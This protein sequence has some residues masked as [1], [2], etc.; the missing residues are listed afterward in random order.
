MNCVRTS[1]YLNHSR[2]IGTALGCLLA[3]TVVLQCS[4]RQYSLQRSCGLGEMQ[5][6]KAVPS[7]A[8]N[9]WSQQA[10]Q[11]RPRPVDPTCGLH[12]L[13]WALYTI[14]GAVLPDVWLEE[15]SVTY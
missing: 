2:A 3:I 15:Q 12:G 1:R 9:R 7:P 13:I 10:V 5:G 8:A 6:C 11:T 14:C 4:A